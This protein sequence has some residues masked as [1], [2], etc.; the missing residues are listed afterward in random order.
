MFL[1]NGT[2]YNDDRI[3]I[4]EL[5]EINKNSKQMWTVLTR[6]NCEGY[7][8]GLAN[9]FESIEEAIE[10]VKEIEPRIPL[11]SLNG[12]PPQNRLPYNK[13]CDELN[14]NGI[15]SCLELF[16][17][18]KNPQREIVPGI[19]AK[20]LDLNFTEKMAAT[21]YA[22]AWNNLDYSFLYPFLSKDIVLESQNLLEPIKS[23]TEV[24]NYFNHK[25]QTMSKASSEYKVSAQVGLVFNYRPCVVISQGDKNNLI[26]TVLFTIKD[27][28]ISR[29]D[30]CSVAPH[31]MEAELT[32]YFPL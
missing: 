8:I 6:R 15:I 28:L 7:P 21:I 30:I 22:K 18:N 14:K 16:E 10:F 11:I 23:K 13:Y 3:L 2:I 25:M 24:L 31:P 12:N 9:E 17:L 19:K 4:L 32:N 26:L 27:E 5:V 1:F 29:I 20:E